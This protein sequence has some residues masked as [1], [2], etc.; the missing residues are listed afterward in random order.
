[1][2]NNIIRKCGVIG[3]NKSKYKIKRNENQSE[4]SEFCSN[5]IEFIKVKD[6]LIVN[7]WHKIN[8]KDVKEIKKR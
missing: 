3:K 7:R 1:M 8:L 6:K 2:E 4:I 5:N